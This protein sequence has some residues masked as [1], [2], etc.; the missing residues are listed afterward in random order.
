[1]QETI[2]DK[3][4]VLRLIGEGSYGTVYLVQHKELNVRYA[5]KLLNSNLS[6]DPLFIDQFKR[7]AETLLRFTHEGCVQVRDFGKVESSGRYY[8]ATDYC[9]GGTLKD[10]LLRNRRIDPIYALQIISDVLNVLQVAHSRDIIHR[11]IKPENIMI[12]RDYKG[13]D[14]VKVLDFGI[15]KLFEIDSRFEDGIQG[16][17]VGTPEYMSPE[18]AM[19]DRDLDFSIDIYATGIL[20]FELLTGSVP[21]NAETVVQVLLMQITKPPTPFA[22]KM[23]M[24]TFIEEMVFKA[25]NKDKLQRYESAEQFRNDCLKAIDSLKQIKSQT[26]K[27]KSDSGIFQRIMVSG[28]E[29]LLP[30]N[31][32]INEITQTTVQTSNK[33]FTEE[34]SQSLD[35]LDKSDKVDKKQDIETEDSSDFKPEIEY[36]CNILCLDDDEKFLNILTYI[37]EH[38]GYRVF[39]TTS[40]SAIHSYLFTHDIKLLVTDVQMPGL[41]GTK[42]CKMLKDKMPDLKIALFSNIAEREL[43]KLAKESNADGWISKCNKPH[44]WLGMIK[45]I[46][47]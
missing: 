16:F 27:N 14:V 40:S 32:V 2:A 20:A 19:G 6:K 25:I 46:I 13:A 21:F 22:I 3:Y 12:E 7:E 47:E 29:P 34:S 26:L 45:E 35:N 15:S 30:A 9:D 42:V 10:L 38:E 44:E 37:L 33:Q 11:D 4:H 18:Q 1:M 23:N 41:P 17:A 28:K 43:E 24:P 5:L 39:S 8:M 31:K 36:K